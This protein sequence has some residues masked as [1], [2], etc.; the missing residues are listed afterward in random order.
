MLFDLHQRPV[1]RF[2]QHK[3]QNHRAN[4]R[5][6]RIEPE[7]AWHCQRVQHGQEQFVGQKAEYVTGAARYAGSSAANGCRKNL[8]E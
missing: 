8:C 4:Q 3:V 2:G 7:R 1:L 5:N 6:G